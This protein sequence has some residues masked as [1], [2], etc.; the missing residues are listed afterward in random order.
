MRSEPVILRMRGRVIEWPRRGCVMGILNINEDSF[1]GDGR[2]DAGWAVERAVA[3]IGEGADF[4]DVGAESARTNREA[5]SVDEEL[6]R[7]ASFA[8]RWGEVVERAEPRDGEQVWPPVLS[9]N[10]W[11]SEVVEGVLEMGYELVNDMS[12]LTS[13]R[14]AELCAQWGGALLVMHTVGEP[15]VDHRHVSWADLGRSMEDFFAERIVRCREAGLSDEQVVLDPGLGFAKGVED[16][17]EVFRALDRLMNFARPILLPVGRKGF[18]GEVLGIEEA[19]ERDA[20]TMACVAAGLRRGGSI[21][22]V[23]EVKGCFE[24]I[25]VLEGVGA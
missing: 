20:G 23:H 6:E 18:V 9:A 7:F 1:S 11:R 8:E 14:N 10:T 5:I 19:S 22:R 12:G 25:K 3:M 2:V 24:V 17:L 21:F 4:L 15:K 16:D 13:A